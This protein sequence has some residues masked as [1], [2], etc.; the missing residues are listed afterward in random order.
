MVSIGKISLNLALGEMHRESLNDCTLVQSYRVISYEVKRRLVVIV[1]ILNTR[2]RP[3]LAAQD[4][5]FPVE[6]A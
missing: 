2:G 3:G 4:A 6:A 1:I 5:R